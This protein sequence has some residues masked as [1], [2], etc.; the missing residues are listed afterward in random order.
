MYKFIF[1]FLLQLS[2]T[3][4]VNAQLLPDYENNN[5]HAIFEWQ[6]QSDGFWI[7]QSDQ[8]VKR[9]GKARGTIIS[10]DKESKCLYSY[11]DTG[12]YRIDLQKEWVAYYTREFKK[13]KKTEAT[14]SDE[15]K[16]IE[17][18]LD[19]KYNG[20]NEK[21]QRIIDEAKIRQEEQNKKM[22]EKYKSEHPEWYILPISKLYS[23]CLLCGKKGA[24]MVYCFSNDTIY[25]ISIEGRVLDEIYLQ[26]HVFPMSKYDTETLSTH[27]NIYKD[28]LIQKKYSLNQAIEF[29]NKELTNYTNKIQKKAPNGFVDSWG[30]NLNSVYGVEPYFS[31]YNLSNKIIK[32]VDFYFS[33]Y[34][35]VGDRCYLKYDKSYIGNVRGVGPIKPFEK[36]YWNWERATHYTTGDASEM[37]INKIVLTYMDKTTKV[38][39]GKNLIIK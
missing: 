31:F 15:L 5:Y 39:T 36:G 34:N 29:N 20:L 8:V 28:S 1:S 19:S 27:I 21:N 4:N 25:T 9:K 17:N 11:D 35:A 10:F 16:R 2:L 7:K 33:L 3:V 18:M 30:W 13:Q 24:D 32:Y 22:I 23:D 26:F 38:L 6:K 37:R 14:L 12:I